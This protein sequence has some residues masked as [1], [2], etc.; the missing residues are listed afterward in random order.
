M[1]R[2]ATHRSHIMCGLL[3]DV[4]KCLQSAPSCMGRLP[5]WIMQTMECSC[6]TAGLSSVAS[7]S[8]RS[9]FDSRRLYGPQCSHHLR[10]LSMRQQAVHSDALTHVLHV[11]FTSAHGLGTDNRADRPLSVAHLLP[12]SLGHRLRKMSTRCCASRNLSI[13]QSRSQ[14][15][16]SAA[17]RASRH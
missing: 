4:W 8:F 11:C 12:E 1:H 15:A 16:E 2:T 13:R 6:Q 10:S 7:G 17:S 9:A 14:S 5:A 3:H